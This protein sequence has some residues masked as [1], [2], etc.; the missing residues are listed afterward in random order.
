MGIIEARHREGT[1]KIDDGGV[2]SLQGKSPGVVTRKEDL[3]VLDCKRM[4]ASR[5]WTRIVGA[6][7]RPGQDAL[8]QGVQDWLQWVIA[9]TSDFVCAY[10]PTLGF[11]QAFGSA[12]L[13]LFV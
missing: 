7:M 9:Q 10:K 8:M 11:Y 5:Q 6:E 3:A 4:D 12:G 2:W 1:L 13:L